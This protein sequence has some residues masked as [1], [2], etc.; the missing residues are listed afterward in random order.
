MNARNVSDGDPAAI[1]DRMAAR[2]EQRRLATPNRRQQAHDRR[3]PTR[4]A[5]D[6]RAI[7]EYCFQAGDHPT[8]AHC[9]RA[10]ERPDRIMDA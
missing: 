9:M 1:D 4:D 5:A 8:P 10:L 3:D 7:C 6:R 2:I